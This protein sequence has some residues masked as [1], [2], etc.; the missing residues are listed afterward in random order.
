METHVNRIAY[1]PSNLHLI[2]PSSVLS[3]CLLATNNKWEFNP[4]KN[5]FSLQCLISTNLHVD[6]IGTSLLIVNCFNGVLLD[7]ILLSLAESHSSSRSIDQNKYL[8]IHS[9]LTGVYNHHYRNSVVIPRILFR[10]MCSLLEHVVF[11]TII[12]VVFHI[13]CI[14]LFWKDTYWNKLCQF[15]IFMSLSVHNCDAGWPTVFEL[16]QEETFVDIRLAKYSGY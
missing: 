4:I 14:R 1:Y 7:N 3:A 12:I 2:G 15:L 16:S 5:D 6:M 8:N 13:Q 9:S 10:C 11:V